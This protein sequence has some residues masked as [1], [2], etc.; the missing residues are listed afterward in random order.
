MHERPKQ[1]PAPSYSSPS[2]VAS[3]L[4]RALV[5]I[6]ECRYAG[7]V[8]CLHFIATTLAHYLYQVSRN[9]LQHLNQAIFDGILGAPMNIFGVTQS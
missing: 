4:Q 7:H 5:A 2:S 8:S 3:G 1:E 9:L 6:S